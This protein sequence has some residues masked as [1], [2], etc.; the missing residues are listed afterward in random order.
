MRHKGR[1]RQ[2]NTYKLH[3]RATDREESL[4]VDAIFHS[5]SYVSHSTDKSPN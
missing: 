5:C 1:V 3:W 2:L 4:R